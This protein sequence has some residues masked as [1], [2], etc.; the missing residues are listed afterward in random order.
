MSGDRNKKALHAA[1]ERWNAGDGDGYFELYDRSLAYY[2]VPG[3]PLDY[4]AT[5]AFYEAM[6]R[7][8]PGGQLTIDEVITEGEMLA[9]RFHLSGDHK[10]PYLGVSATGRSIVL[11]GQTFMRFQDGRVVQR[12]TTGDL[13]G[14][15]VQLG[16]IPAPAS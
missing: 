10:A 9:C 1:I 5:R 15:L 13:L 8:F 14:L 3:E 7:A 6:W 12:W 2:G 4:A 16:A 11:P